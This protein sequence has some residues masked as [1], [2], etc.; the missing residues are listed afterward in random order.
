MIDERPVPIIPAQ[1]IGPSGQVA[2]VEQHPDEAIRFE[3]VRQRFGGLQKLIAVVEPCW[4]DQAA[5]GKD[6]G[7]LPEVAIRQIDP[8]PLP[9]V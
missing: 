6:D 9:P 8:P 2:A 5:D 4:L 1:P 3:V 7:G